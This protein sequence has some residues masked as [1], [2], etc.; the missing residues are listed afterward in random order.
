MTTRSATVASTAACST[1]SPR[2]TSS[3]WPPGDP[4]PR[5]ATPSPPSCRRTG[6]TG[7]C[8]TCS[9]SSGTA[10]AWPW[11]SA[12]GTG[13]SAAPRTSS[14]TRPGTRCWSTV[15]KPTS[16]AAP[17][18]T[19]TPGTSGSTRRC[20]SAPG[21]P[22][23]MPPTWSPTPAS[24][25]RSTCWS[26]TSTAWT[27]GSG[28]RCAHLRPRV[29]V[30]EVNPYLGD[31][32]VTLAYDPD[33]VRPADVAFASTS[34]PAMAALA[35]ELGYRF[36]GDRAVRDQRLLRSRG[37]GASAAAR[38]RDSRGAPRALGPPQRGRDRSRARALPHVAAV[39]GRPAVH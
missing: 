33:F 11:R 39:D 26:S 20:S 2:S 1:C 19:P 24:A 28:S 25:T 5:S 21:S 16:S 30:T 35:E 14:S 37:P 22:P 9:P 12:P 7:S 23:R 29:V 8:C 18:S 34:L 36:V 27:S 31:E 10:I 15:T 17:P 38:R 32:R 13:S 3:S 4:C 6:R